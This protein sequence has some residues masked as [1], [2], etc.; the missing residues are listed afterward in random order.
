MGLENTEKT[1]SEASVQTQL[2]IIDE[3][4]SQ[5]QQ[6]LLTLTA[7]RHPERPRMTRSKSP[8]PLRD[9]FIR[10]GGQIAR[11]AIGGFTQVANEADKLS[12]SDYMNAQM[13]RLPVEMRDDPKFY[14][15]ESYARLQQSYLLYKGFAKVGQGLAAV[16]DMLLNYPS[17]ALH[18]VG[19]GF[20]W[21]GTQA[22]RFARD[23]LGFSQRI[24]QNAGDITEL[25][26]QIFAPA[27]IGSV[28]KSSVVAAGVTK[29]RNNVAGA[30]ARVGEGV[31]S[32]ESIGLSWTGNWFERGYAFE[33]Y[34]ASKLPSNWRLPLNFKTFDFFGDGKAVSVKTLDTNTL[35][36]IANPETIRYQIN[37]YINKMID[38][39]EHRR[40]NEF[41]ERVLLNRSKISNMELHLAVP[42]NTSP[43]HL[44]QIMHSV[45][46]GVDN[47]VE[48][49]VTKVK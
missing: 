12:I 25:A 16:D 11:T 24:A 30:F 21:L 23:N 34:I 13:L 1:V 45:Q 37:G 22:R 19:E 31:I 3:R 14:A 42:A 7:D 41:G 44:R 38:F 33:N 18:A 47:G 2:G 26:A 5:Y 10:Q 17:K 9:T 8:E 29:F 36:R 46:H 32:G 15:S 6:I 4:M 27:A 39:T 48:V 49:I 43:M 40:H 35:A 20:E 28:A